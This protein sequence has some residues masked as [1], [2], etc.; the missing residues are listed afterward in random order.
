MVNN[1]VHLWKFFD[2]ASPRILY[3]RMK[4][5]KLLMSP[6]HMI[7][8]GVALGLAPTPSAHLRERHLLPHQLGKR[9]DGLL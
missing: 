9:A 4:R 5:V 7:L 2:K 6:K 1:R 3:Y 8:A